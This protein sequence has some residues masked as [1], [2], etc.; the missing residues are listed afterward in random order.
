MTND[1][2]GIG[3]TILCILERKFGYGRQGSYCTVGIASVH[4][5]SAGCERLAFLIVRDEDGVIVDFKTTGEFPKYG[6]DDDRVDTI[7][8]DIV[9]KFM[10]A[11]NIRQPA[12]PSYP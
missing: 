2:V 8:Q 4:R 12:I 3:N 10:T 5:V 11:I 9:H 1:G 6:N 7:A